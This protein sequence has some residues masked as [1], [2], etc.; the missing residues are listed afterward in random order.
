VSSSARPAVAV[1]VP[2]VLLVLTAACSSSAAPKP[3]PTSTGTASTPRGTA[4]TSTGST[5]TGIVTGIDKMIGGA[6]AG[7]PYFSDPY[8]VYR[9][10]NATSAP[11]PHIVFGTPDA[12]LLCPGQIRPGCYTRRPID[13]TMSA[14]LTAQANAAGTVIVGTQNH[15]PFQDASGAWNMA[16][17][18]SVREKSGHPS[19]HWTVVLHAHP[20]GAVNPVPTEWVADSVLAGSLAHSEDA[21]YDG[22]YYEANGILYLLYSKR[23]S[24]N[25][26][27]DGVVAQE[28]TSPE[29]PGDSGPVVLLQ[30]TSGTGF[31]SEDFFLNAPNSSFKLVETGNIT[32]IDGKYVM[33]YSTG[34]FAENDYKTG[35]AWSDTFLPHAGSTYA[36]LITPDPSNV[37]QDPVDQEVAYLMQSQKPKGLHY[38]GGEVLAPGVPSIVQDG[39]DWYLIFAGYQPGNSPGGRVPTQFDPA[40]R[41]PYLVPLCLTGSASIIVTCTR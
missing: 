39:S 36:K 8:P 25:P 24:D 1:L 41:Q 33:A 12:V 14:A 27:R 17:T 10:S 23:L 18:V 28:L 6:D 34:D 37:W 2:L 26:G 22:K 11:D 32:Q 29:Q 31:A 21:N 4:S 15:N 38:V 7:S 9:V 16:L 3:A 40:H 20:V 13:I 35:I 19:G 5:G 30:P